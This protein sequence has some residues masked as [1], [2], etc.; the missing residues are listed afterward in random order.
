MGWQESSGWVRRKF[1]RGVTPQCLPTPFQVL[2]V[3]LTT[4]ESQDADVECFSAADLTMHLDDEI[5]NCEFVA[6]TP[7][8]SHCALTTHPVVHTDQF[9]A[10]YRVLNSF[11]LMNAILSQ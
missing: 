9:Q 10:M 5:A 1:S 6:L 8:G 11:A 3:Y 4:S 2:G 7:S